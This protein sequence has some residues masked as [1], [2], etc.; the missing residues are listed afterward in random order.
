MKF[1]YVILAQL[2]ILNLYFAT[3]ILAQSPAKLALQKSVLKFSSRFDSTSITP[4]FLKYPKLSRFEKDLR[5]FYQDRDYLY[6]WFQQGKLIEQS[7]NLTNRIFNLKNDGVFQQFSYSGTLDSLI[8]KD[9]HGPEANTQL[10]LLL[11]AG[12]FMFSSVVWDG[13]DLATSKDN[14]WFLPRK[15]IAYNL[16]LDSLI[17]S[18]NSDFSTEEP[19]Y[20]QY[21]LLKDNL[22]KYRQLDAQD[23]WI[24]IAG[25]VKQ[26]KERLLKLGDYRNESQDTLSD[27]ELRLALI[28]FQQRHGINESGKI[29]KQTLAELNVPIKSRIMQIVVNMERSRWLPIQSNGDYVAVN[30]PEF[31]MH[32]YHA[33]SLLWS[34]NAVVGKTVH[35]T[36]LF[37]GEINQVVFSPYWNIP[38]SIVRKE[39]LPGIKRNPSYLTKHNMEI[40]GQRNGLPVVRQRPGLTNSLGLVKFLFPNN[41]SIYLHDTPSKSLFNE[42]A[43]A[44]SHGCIRIEQPSKLAAFL[45]KDDNR[46]SNSAIKLAMNA[47]KE[48]PVT[49]AN[50]VPVYIAY[51]TAFIDR[52]NRL[53]FRNDI[54]QMDAG[55]AATIFSAAE[56]H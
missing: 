17:Q 6:A 56:N 25:D 48:R 49:I 18:P 5:A 22:R 52:E 41:Y 35:P 38:E 45:L 26:V 42:T 33:D 24:T 50:T 11:T 29:D 7:G 20:R 28:R 32:V 13:M 55:L 21:K 51:L 39:I 27:A 43:R 8:H 19:V 47:G 54:Y 31:K 1:K 46:W 44:F 16:Y 40:T 34:C 2:L 53:N 30:I 3:D 37:Y 4:F 10:E 9:D 23:N 14:S 12:Y 36:T 15:K